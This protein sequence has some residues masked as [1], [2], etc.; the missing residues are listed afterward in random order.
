M[1]KRL[2]V[3]LAACFFL[4][5]LSL[6]LD[7]REMGLRIL[8]DNVLFL[9]FIPSCLSFSTAAAVSSAGF[10]VVLGITLL[11][12]RVYCSTI[13]PLGTGQDLISC[14][15][16]KRRLDTK[17]NSKGGGYR[18]SSPHSGLRSALL[19]LT[20]L[21]LLG[22]NNLALNLLDPFSSFGRI[23]ANLVRPLVLGL[24]N[25]GAM[26]AES[27]GGTLLYQV[28]WPSLA[29]VSVGISL[30]ILILVGW[31]SAHHGRLYCN[32]LCPVG[33]LLGL[34]ARCSLLGLRFTQDRCIQCG[35]CESVCKAACIDID[36][37]Q[38]DLSRCVSCY[39][40]LSVCPTQ[41]IEI[42]KTR[43]RRSATPRSPSGRRQFLL[44]LFAG[45]MELLTQRTEDGQ[46]RISPLQERPTT[47]SEKK[48]CPIS[49][50]GSISVAH[51][52]SHCTAC[53]LCVSAC[54][55]Q[56]LR[57]SFVGYGLSSMLQPQLDFRTGH[58]NFECTIC[59]EICPSGAI[60][61]LTRKAKKQTQVGVARFIRENCVV[62]TDKT[63]CGACSEHC[64]TKAV[65]MVPYPQVGG[66]KLRIPEVNG[67]ICVG[68]GGCEH[69]CPTRPYKA[70]YVDG[71]PVHKL[72]E[73]PEETPVSVPP[74][75]GEDFPF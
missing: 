36:L 47:I 30:A 48:N 66:R 28:Q 68:C 51:F 72:A 69:A 21:L 35:A 64:P 5:T 15:A 31:M 61:P 57:P 7:F 22:E 9:Q 20:V 70:I 23:M 3:T 17:K 53:H 33:T 58:C 39:N 50:P 10:V 56:V 74:P 52:N 25:L 45:G 38:I 32:T 2:R 16:R 42:G 18:F 73:K 27:V 63:N 43:H 60:L 41:A 24:N 62:F 13:C 49:P 40:C 1:L 19:S 54:P 55:S 6:F 29:P 11:F 12:G 71:N 37:G 14:L 8:A 26:V 65:H 75:T 46:Q 44:T 67:A 34:V 59:T 4:L